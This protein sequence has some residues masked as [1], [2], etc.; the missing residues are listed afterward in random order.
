MLM[1][2]P[3]FSSMILISPSFLLKPL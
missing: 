1:V 2:S 3:N